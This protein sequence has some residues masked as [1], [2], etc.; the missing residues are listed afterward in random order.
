MT[1]KDPFETEKYSIK[2]REDGIVHTNF[3]QGATID[4]ECQDQMKICFE[5]LT[6]SVKRPFIYTADGSVAVTKEAQIN[7]H[8]LD[9]QIPI[10]GSVVITKNTAQK[11]IADFYYLMR[12]PVNPLKIYTRFE[13][14]INW[15][16]TYHPVFK[17]KMEKDKR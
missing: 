5:A 6:A 3:K 7:A 14:G 1:S 17:V 8:E 4:L 16:N 15:L 12:P 11:L 10:T 13:K 2:L 9:R